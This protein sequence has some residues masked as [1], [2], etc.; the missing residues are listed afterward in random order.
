MKGTTMFMSLIF[1]TAGL[2]IGGFAMHLFKERG[3]LARGI[4]IQHQISTAH[5]E[6]FEDGWNA[7]V[8]SAFTSR[9]EYVKRFGQN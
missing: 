6:G 1:G 5:A 9:A 3:H 4:A 7:A 2:A 8:E